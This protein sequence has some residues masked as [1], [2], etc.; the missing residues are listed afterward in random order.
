MPQ[1]GAVIEKGC[2]RTAGSLEF[3]GKQFAFLF[4]LDFTAERF[5][6]LSVTWGR[7]GAFGWYGP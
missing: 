3:H 1:S 6:G 5:K 4:G 7:N 2:P